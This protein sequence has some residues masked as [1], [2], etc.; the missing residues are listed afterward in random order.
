L[1]FPPPTECHPHRAQPLQANEQAK[2][3]SPTNDVTSGDSRVCVC[4]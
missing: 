3:H 4:A 1:T 2:A